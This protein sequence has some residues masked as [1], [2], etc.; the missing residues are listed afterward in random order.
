M[1]ELHMMF[2]K[3]SIILF[4]DRKKKATLPP[5]QHPAGEKKPPGWV[6]V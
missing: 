4:S 1:G 2:S 5:R 6:V 3:T